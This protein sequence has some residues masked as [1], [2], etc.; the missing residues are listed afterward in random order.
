MLTIT[1]IFEATNKTN[2][3]N[4]NKRR[5]HQATVNFQCGIH[6]QGGLLNLLYA[7]PPSYLGC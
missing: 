4:I 5:S 7:S 6:F 3:L 2:I 1:S